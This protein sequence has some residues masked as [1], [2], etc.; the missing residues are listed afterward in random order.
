MFFETKLL[1]NQAFEAD[2]LLA[3]LASINTMYFSLENPRS[4]I[5]F[6]ALTSSSD[7]KKIITLRVFHN[8]LRIPIHKQKWLGTLKRE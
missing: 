8:T 1:Y 5:I 7:V 6:L 4:L 3:L 2:T